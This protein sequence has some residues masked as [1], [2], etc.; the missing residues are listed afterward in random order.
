MDGLPKDSAAF[1][2]FTDASK[3]SSSNYVGSACFCPDLNIRSS[4]SIAHNASVFTA[5]CIALSDALDIALS[6]NNTNFLIY[7]DSLSVLQRIRSTKYDVRT[8][9]YIL[10]IK[11]KYN[12]FLH[13]N[14]NNEI[15]FFWITSHS[16]IRGNDIVDGLAKSVTVSSA[17]DIPRIL[18]TDLSESL[19]KRAFSHTAKIIKDQGIYKCKF[20]FQ[21]YCSNNCMPWYG[22]KKHPGS[23]LLL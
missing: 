20:Y 2:I 23:L 1:S 16:G 22:N 3:I 6:N 17:L 5:E 21:H 9:I 18:F 12:Q 13:G 8:N 11:K 19:K 15:R 10:D 14:P 7:S 4:K